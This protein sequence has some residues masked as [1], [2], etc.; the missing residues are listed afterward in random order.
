[1]KTYAKKMQD[2]VFSIVAYRG[3]LDFMIGRASPML[4][5]VYSYFGMPKHSKFSK[6]LRAYVIDND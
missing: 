4:T 5:H 1:M 6:L 3:I 2:G